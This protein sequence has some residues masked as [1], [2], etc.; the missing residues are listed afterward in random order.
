M[1]KILT[2][3]VLTAL[4]MNAQAQ[5]KNQANLPK[6]AIKA[7]DSEAWIKYM[8]PTPIQKMLK[9]YS[10]SLIERVLIWNINEERPTM[11]EGG[12]TVNMV[13]GDRFMEIVH[14]GRYM[15]M[16]YDGISTLSYDNV[17]EKFTS[18]W[19]DNQGNTLMFAE[20]SFDANAK[21]IE[22][23][24]YAIDPRS[25]ATVAARQ[26]YELHGPEFMAIM[27]YMQIDD[28]EHTLMRVELRKEPKEQE[29]LSE[30]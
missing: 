19:V 8:R 10:G 15:A 26:V 16:Q 24:G 2:I 6:A 18:T 7:D 25:G 9:R 4:G 29:Q 1:K 13:L 11:I 5:A 3:A 27:T 23:K 20:G 28:K 17:R 21:T 12:A 30:Q 14:S 22:L